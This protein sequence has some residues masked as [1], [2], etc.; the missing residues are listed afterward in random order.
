SSS[1]SSSSSSSPSPSPS[2]SPVFYNHESYNHRPDPLSFFKS[3]HGG[4]NISNS[5]YWASAAFIG[6]HG[7]AMACILILGGLG[8]GIYLLV[9]K[10]LNCCSSSSSYVGIRSEHSNSYYIIPFLV[11]VLCTFIAITSSGCVLGANHKSLLRTKKL[12]NTLFRVATD[13]HIT[14]RRVTKAM[15]DMRNLLRPYNG[16]VCVQLRLASRKLSN[17]SQMIRRVVGRLRHSINKANKIWQVLQLTLLM[18]SLPCFLILRVYLVTPYNYKS[19]NLMQLRRC[20]I[21][22]LDSSCKIIFLCWILSAICWI[23]TGFHFFLHTFAQDTCSAFEEFQQN[24]SNNSLT[25]IL[26]CL[27]QVYADQIMIDLGSAVHTFLHSS[28]SYIENSS[29]GF[30]KICNPFSSAPDYSYNP[31]SCSKDAILISDIPHVL[32]QFTCVKDTS[33]GSCGVNRK[34]ISKDS[35][36][37]VLAYAETIQKLLTILPDIQNLAQCSF[38]KDTISDVLS[39]QCRPFKL[40]FKLLCLSTMILSTTM[41][42]LELAWLAKLY[43]NKGRRFHKCSVIPS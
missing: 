35:S 32:R 24:P 13:A 12:E 28:I 38:V 25:P 34:F 14:I 8:F 15:Q 2:F 20:C 37:M 42:I 41:V 26:P 19:T 5:H 31:S 22:A 27:D 1:S 9:I 43:Q 16:A 21:G 6:I 4:Y 18:V 40:S 33:N 39:H 29:K 11:V 36:D 7:Y 10:N 3:Y 30:F 17:E 23:L